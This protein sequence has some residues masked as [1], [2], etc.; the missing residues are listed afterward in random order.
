MQLFGI[1]QSELCRDPKDLSRPFRLT[2]MKDMNAYKHVS[3]KEIPNYISPYVSIT[4]ENFD[5]S[6]MASILIDDKDIKST[7]LEK[8]IMN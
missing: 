1:M 2:D 4:S 5:E 8:I 6:L 7:P 3:I